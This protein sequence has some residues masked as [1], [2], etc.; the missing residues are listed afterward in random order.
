MHKVL[1]TTIVDLLFDEAQTAKEI[2]E[3][4]EPK[5]TKKEY[6][7]FLG[8]STKEIKESFKD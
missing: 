6:L 7:E 1:A 4:F 8:E 3:N 2:I 5:L